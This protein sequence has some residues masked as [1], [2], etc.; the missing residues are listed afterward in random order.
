MFLVIVHVGLVHD[1]VATRGWVL[2]GK[3]PVAGVIGN[4]GVEVRDGLVDDV[5][6]AL[7]LDVVRINPLDDL[8]G[9]LRRRKRLVDPA[10][11]I[12]RAR[13][14][15]AQGLAAKFVNLLEQSALSALLEQGDRRLERNELGQ[16][17]HVDA[18][19]VGIANLGCG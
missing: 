18:V 1:S 4:R 17:R 11:V 7:P 19:A 12:H 2:P 14:L 5:H 10:H 3:I 15:A 9:N 16:L 13:L 8:R 6:R